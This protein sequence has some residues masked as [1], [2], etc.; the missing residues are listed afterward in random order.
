[1]EPHPDN[2]V[3]LAS[4]QIGFSQFIVR[5]L[6]SQGDQ[7]NPWITMK[8]REDILILSIQYYSLFA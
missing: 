4:L 6:G 3:A 5:A 8:N 2:K 1:M 7:E